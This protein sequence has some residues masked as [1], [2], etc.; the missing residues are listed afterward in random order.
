MKEDY[1]KSVSISVVVLETKR[2]KL[3]DEAVAQLLGYYFKSKGMNDNQM[4]VA[5]LLNEYKKNVEIR[6]VL[7]PYCDDEKKDMASNR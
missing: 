7:F 6:L 1:I 3:P 2:K 5:V 4:G